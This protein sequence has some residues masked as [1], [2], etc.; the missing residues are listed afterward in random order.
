MAKSIASFAGGGAVVHDNRIDPIL[1]EDILHFIEDHSDFRQFIRVIPTD[2]YSLTSPRKWNA[3]IAVEIVEGA[4]I[5]KFRDV[6][7]AVTL[8]VRAIATGIK[9]T[10]EEQKMMGFDSNYFQ[11]EGKRATERLLKKENDDIAAVLLAGAGNIIDTQ[12]TILTFKDVLEAKTQMTESPYQVEP[13]IIIMSQRSY[14]DLL[15]D[16]NFSRYCYSG[17]QGAYQTGSVGMEIDGMAIHIIKEVGD[18]VYLIDSTKDWAVLL[19]MDSVHTESYRLPETREDVLDILLYEKPAVLRPDAIT[20]IAIERT[21]A[22]GQR[23]VFED[24]VDL[25]GESGWDPLDKYPDSDDDPDEKDPKSTLVPGGQETIEDK[26]EPEAETY[27][28]TSYA[29]AKGKTQYATG[30]VETTGVKTQNYVQ[31]EVKTNSPD[32]DPSFIGRKFYVDAK[33]LTDGSKLYRLFEKAGSKAI[34][35]WVRITE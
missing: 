4:E 24:M 2:S 25:F 16:P 23:L 7:D 14:N 1:S 35:V 5:P 18:N 13:D 28:F 9:M 26:E 3:G 21:P 22:D 10:D 33:A 17:V 30:T 31:V 29:D 12:E 11:T 32:P 8:N 34:D 19:Q 20:K 15:L 6:F 27:N